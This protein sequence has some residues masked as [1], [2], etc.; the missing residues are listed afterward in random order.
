MLL[1]RKRDQS[2]T[3]LETRQNLLTILFRKAWQ[4]L[5]N[6]S[7]DIVEQNKGLLLLLSIMFFLCNTDEEV[8]LP[9]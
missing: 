7:S 8:I 2:H 5:E 1:Q 4:F 3:Q 9:S 6:S